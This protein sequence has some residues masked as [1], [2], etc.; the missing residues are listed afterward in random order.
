MRGASGT[1]RVVNNRY[2][3]S[4]DFYRRVPRDLTEA[5]TLGAVMSLSCITI[6]V[7]LF[8]SETYAFL[9]SSIT[10]SVDVDDKF[11]SPQIKLNFDVSIYD[12]PCEYLSVD[13]LDSIGANRQNITKNVEKWHLDDKGVKRGYYGRNRE[14]KEIEHESHYD[15]E[16]QEIE[17]DGIPGEHPE[18]LD[19]SS[20]ESFINRNEGAFINFYAPWCVWCQR[21]HPTWDKFAYAMREKKMKAGVAMVDCVDQRILCTENGVRAFPTLRWFE[22]GHS[23]NPDYHGDRTT[24]AFIN[25]VE[26][27]V[28]A[29][30][31]IQ[32]N[33]A[34]KEHRKN[35]RHKN[36]EGCRVLGFIMVNRVPGNFH[37]IARSVNH[38]L[39]IA[40]TNLSHTVNHLSFGEG[41]QR[42]TPKM[43]RIFRNVPDSFKQ[44]K[45][46]D[47]LSYITT[48]Y[49]K[50]FHHNM[51]VVST[52]F[53]MGGSFSS[54]PSNTLNTYQFLSQSQVVEYNEMNVPEARFSY[55][56]SPMSVVVQRKGRKWYD[57]VT[58]L[59]AIIGGTFT[60]LGLIDA[61]LYKV[62]K[63]KK[64]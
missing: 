9:I 33:P 39:H 11:E 32:N 15:E 35:T 5:T 58:S 38:N 1:K 56:I 25:F 61:S 36:E 62:L 59:C 10:T 28:R 4:V 48:Q 31:R 44:F 42:P 29:M 26:M 8:F 20:F 52:Y 23:V 57:Y 54:S 50:A 30:D 60:T 34:L 53:D 45:P 13:V 22:N 6:M 43:K 3:P 7:V 24:D 41:H 49:H 27:K 51:K 37:L 2:Q 12:L 55:D 14:Q 40:M 47:G 19:K 21:L 64:L 17:F 18:V 46:L 16:G 63:S